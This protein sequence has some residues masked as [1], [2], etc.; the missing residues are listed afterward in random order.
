MTM[1]KKTTVTQDGPSGTCG[2][3]KRA[4]GF[5][6]KGADGLPIFCRC[7]DSKKRVLI[8][9]TKPACEQFVYARE[10]FPTEGMTFGPSPDR[11]EEAGEK[12]D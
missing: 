7:S 8:F 1:A 2:Q 5:C 9:C 6:I 12:R 4:F 10:S 3:C 11:E